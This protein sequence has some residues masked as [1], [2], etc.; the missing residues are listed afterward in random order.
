MVSR[1]RSKT[2]EL[3]MPNEPETEYCSSSSASNSSENS[4]FSSTCN[5][6][7]ISAK[8]D[9][10][11]LGTPD[12]MAPEMLLGDSFGPE[13]DWWAL[14][15]IVFEFLMGYRPFTAETPE[16]IFNNVVRQN[17]RSGPSWHCVCGAFSQLSR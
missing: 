15:V 4:S 12:Y 7:K 6:P 14:G 16:D 1:H 10:Q 2:Q 8:R 17:I 9:R 11:T 5:M 3:L 13:V